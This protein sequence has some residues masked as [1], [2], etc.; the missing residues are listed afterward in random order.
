MVL[1]SREGRHHR[2][3]CL[4]ARPSID[5]LQNSKAVMKVAAGVADCSACGVVIAKEPKSVFTP[6]NRACDVSAT[7]HF[8]SWP[9]CWRECTEDGLPSP[10]SQLT[11]SPPILVPVFFPFGLRHFVEMHSFS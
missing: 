2:L 8:K 7:F 3:N 9:E 11:S 1:V 6:V 5:P 4:F 10:Y